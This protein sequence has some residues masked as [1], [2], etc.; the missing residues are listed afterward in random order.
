MATRQ[1]EQR[2]AAAALGATGDVHFLGS[3][4]GEL[5]SD[6]TTRGEVARVIRV[7]R[8]DVVLGHD[9]WKRYRL[10]PDHRAA[11][12]LAVD[13]IVAARDPFFFPE[14]GLA[15]H[16]PDALLLFEAEAPDHH[17]TTVG[18]AA[19]KVAAL[20]EHRS[21]FIT[22]HDITDP[23]DPAQVARFAD[24]VEAALTA[25]GDQVGVASA[26]LY[27]LIDQL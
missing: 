12:Q 15:H 3:V 2:S 17:E 9:P 19:T 1:V 18:F 27:K 22:T 26:E 10:H 23:D 25:G 4:D 6:L 8:P 16:R 11:G 5:D 24:W 13:G 21:Q 7:V 14:H 20:L